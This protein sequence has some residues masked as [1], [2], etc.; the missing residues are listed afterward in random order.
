M[1]TPI[2][3][4]PANPRLFEFR[5]RPLALICATEHYGAVINRR[6]D[7]ERYL[8]EHAAKKQTLSRLFLLFRELQGPNN[9]YSTC[10]PESTDF[11]APWP[12]TGPGKAADGEPR[13]DL[14]RWNDEYFERLHRFCGLASELGI[15]IEVTLFSNSYGPNI[16]QLNPL[17]AP[18]NL[19][20]IGDLDFNEY[21]TLRNTALWE[22]QQAHVR[23]AVTELNHYDNIYFEICN[24][25]GSMDKTQVP[26]AEIDEWQTAVAR[27]VREVEADLPNRHLIFGTQAF[28]F[29]PFHQE[30]D[31]AF[32]WTHIDAANV[33]ALPDTSFRGRT[34]NMGVFMSKE[35]K[36]EEYRAF[37]LAVADVPKPCVQDEDNVASRYLDPDGWTI[38]R[39][40]AW[41][42]LLCGAHYDVIDFSI[43]IHTPTGT[44]DSRRHI[45]SWLQYLSEFVH[46]LDLPRARPL[47]DW[48]LTKP[49]GLLEAT[50]AVEGEDYAAYLADS[51]E[52]DDS[53]WG[54]AIEGEVSFR[55]PAGEFMVR[56]YAP[57]SGGYSPGLH[58]RGDEAITLAL[59]AFSHDIVVR[60]TRV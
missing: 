1:T 35:L 58:V 14:S 11:V 59:P 37:N 33:H 24:E 31:A 48:L 28:T 56:T 41:M 3:I 42:A 23:K 21:L 9:P 10:K 44:E 43:T 4:H 20:G 49:A 27:L 6:F 60:I 54:A 32:S 40:R 22:Q 29:T 18:N 2:R 5:G 12:R 46:S 51:R 26:A 25:P 38:H 36:L 47:G 52:V 30:N 55:L 16:W 39:K 8:H 15:I 7:F 13:Y 19:Q 57:V 50:L 34:Y 45:R 17:N 53:Q